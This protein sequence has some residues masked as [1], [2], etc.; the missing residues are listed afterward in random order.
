MIV[1]AVLET[2]TRLVCCF[3]SCNICELCDP[4]KYFVASLAE[5]TFALN[6]MS[7]DI[8]SDDFDKIVN[9]MLEK[10][11]KRNGSFM[12]NSSAI[13][14]FMCTLFKCLKKTLSNVIL[15]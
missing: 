1:I 4:L 7:T 5:N 8:L 13:Y 6:S 3:I 15:L 2:K 14:L 12:V 9:T 11:L 10:S